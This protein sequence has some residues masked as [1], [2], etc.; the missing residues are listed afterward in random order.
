MFEARICS[1][2]ALKNILFSLTDVVVEKLDEKETFVAVVD[3]KTIVVDELLLL[4]N[5]YYMLLFVITGTGEGIRIQA[6]DD[7]NVCLGLLN[8]DADGFEY[9]R[10]DGSFLLGLNLAQL[11]KVV[12]YAK[13]A[14]RVIFSA[15]DNQNAFEIG[16]CAVDGTCSS[17]F[18]LAFMTCGFDR[19][20]I[21]VMYFLVKNEQYILLCKS[22]KQLCCV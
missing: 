11:V 15:L 2:V 18:T 16:L 1:A 22:N 13:D 6:I 3:C 14:D 8:L 4:L 21:P 20:L 10:C 17:K 9:Y 12:K 19:Y 5:I 7:A